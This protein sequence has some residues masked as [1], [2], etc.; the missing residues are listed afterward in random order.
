VELS[1][2]TV[3]QR[4]RFVVRDHGPGLPRKICST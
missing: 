2:E 1:L 4:V 3:G